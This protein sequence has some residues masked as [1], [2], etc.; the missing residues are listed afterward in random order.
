[1]KYLAIVLLFVM[2][3]GTAQASLI[4][5]NGTITDL[6]LGSFDTLLF[7]ATP[8][9]SSEALETSTLATYLGID[10]SALTIQQEEYT[11]PVAAG[12]YMSTENAMEVLTYDFGTGFDADYFVLKIGNGNVGDTH[13]YFDNA[14]TL[15]YAYIGVQDM[16]SESLFPSTSFNVGRISHVSDFNGTT[17]SA[18][19]LPA[20]IWLF[21]AGLL[22]FVGLG[23][24]TSVG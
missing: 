13:Y 12:W 24:R 8:G 4:N 21:G 14:E 18:V 15:Q 10:S 22:G 3:I 6:N 23:R 20:S 11:D 17:V 16:F 7:S 2:S 19:P 1:M 9:N 5:I